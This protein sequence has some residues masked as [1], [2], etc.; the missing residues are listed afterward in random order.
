MY[1]S[2][3]NLTL[4]LSALVTVAADDPDVPEFTCA[5]DAILTCCQEYVSVAIGLYVGNASQCTFPYL[6]VV[7]VAAS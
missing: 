6:V 4:L 1:I 2:L 7:R 3:R 5:T